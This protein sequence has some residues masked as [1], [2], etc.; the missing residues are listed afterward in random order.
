MSEL[1]RKRRGKTVEGEATF[2]SFCC[3]AIELFQAVSSQRN[4]REERKEREKGFSLVRLG[5]R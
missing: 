2:V 3:T 4:A 5:K 1:K